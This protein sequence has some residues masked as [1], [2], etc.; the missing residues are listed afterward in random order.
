[1]LYGLA[2]IL[3]RAGLRLFY[4]HIHV[5]GMEHIPSQGPVI[6]IANHPSSLMDAA[7]LG[8]LLKRRP[9]YFTRGDVFINRP[10][11]KILSWLHMIPVHP[12][13]KGRSSLGANDES[14]LEARH[15]LHH[16]GI[17]V[18]FPESTSHT[19]HQLW[20]FRKGVFRLA[21]QTM[22]SQPF[23]HRLPVVPVGITYDH[24]RS[25]RQCVQVHAGAPLEMSDY[26]GLYQSNP[27]AALLRM[28]KDAQERV[29]NEVLHIND[30]DRCAVVNQCLMLHRNNY[31]SR[32]RT[33]KITSRTKLQEE[34]AI[35]GHINEAGETELGE[36]K[37]KNEA[38]FEALAKYG[39]EDKTVGRLTTKTYKVFNND[40]KR[41]HAFA[42]LIGF[43]RWKR[44]LLWTGFLLHLAGLVLNGLPIWT[45]RRIV[46]KKVSRE[47]FYSWIFVSCCC[48]L[49]APWAIILIAGA[50]LIDWQY[51]LALL[52][53]MPLTGLFSYYYFDWMREAQQYRK[54]K[55]LSEQELKA[56]LQMRAW[57][58]NQNL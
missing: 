52:A 12:H 1:M 2:K 51:A 25:A 23:S 17:I 26:T 53:L 57:I 34:Q 29:G 49:Y 50:W 16:N 27:S 28:A 35:C 5:S 45:A 54:L 7:L 14:F 31:P 8:V 13:E 36:I 44:L 3:M 21:F 46:D 42:D 39:L 38:Y 56:L 33:W 58:S 55:R 48:L 15:L 4:R 32:I 20:P 10:V 9:W 40:Q 6:I 18:F 22:A 24:P 47:D 11:R 43:S 19:Q 37:K 41:S 30:I